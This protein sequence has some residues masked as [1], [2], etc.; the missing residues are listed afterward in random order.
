MGLQRLRHPMGH[1]LG[2]PPPV[3]GD[4]EVDDRGTRRPLRSP[5]RQRD[6]VGLC[7]RPCERE[8]QCRASRED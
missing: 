3:L 1:L 2:P 7:G 8:R 6:R 5:G 4:L